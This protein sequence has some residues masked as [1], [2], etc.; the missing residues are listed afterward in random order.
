MESQ[1]FGQENNDDRRKEDLAEILG[2]SNKN[3]YIIKCN[4]LINLMTLKINYKIYCLGRVKNKNDL[5]ISPPLK[6]SKKI[7]T[8][9]ILLCLKFRLFETL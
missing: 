5:N 8:G 3:M 7:K 6:I 1:F 4:F 2:R 9:F